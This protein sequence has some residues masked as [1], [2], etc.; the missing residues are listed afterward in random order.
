MD[1][2]GHGAAG[3]S[4]TS[5]LPI[6]KV[7]VCLAEQPELTRTH[8]FTKEMGD[9]HSLI[10]ERDVTKYTPRACTVPSDF[11]FQVHDGDHTL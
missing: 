11:V 6:S 2:T 10:R 7:S 8:A 5:N 1:L 4:N 3:G 9:V